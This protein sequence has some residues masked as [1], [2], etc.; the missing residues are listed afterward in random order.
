[1]VRPLP[2]I[3]GLPRPYLHGYLLRTGYSGNSTLALFASGSASCRALRKPGHANSHYQELSRP[4]CASSC[5]HVGQDM[6]V[7]GSESGDACTPRA[8]EETGAHKDGA[9]TRAVTFSE[10]LNFSPCIGYTAF[11]SVRVQPPRPLSLGQ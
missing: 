5:M 6:S 1:M 8:K 7:S 11:L 10:V 3:L 9:V 2:A 4:V